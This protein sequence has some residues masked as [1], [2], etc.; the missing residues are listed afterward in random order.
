MEYVKPNPVQLKG[1]TN[2]GGESRLQEL[3][4]SDPS[5]LGLDGDVQLI[6]K[7]FQLPEGQRIDFLLGDESNRLQYEVEVQLGDLDESHIIRI[8]EYWDIMRKL[9]P[10]QRHIAVIVAE[11]ITSRFF[12]VI[13]LFNQFIP[14]VAIQVSGIEMDGKFTLVFTK[15]LDISATRTESELEYQ[16]TDRVYWESKASIEILK[17]ADKI[18]E[19]AKEFYPKIVLKYNKGYIGT[20]IDGMKSN[21][22]M[23]WPRKSIL[24]L[25]I[26]LP[27]SPEND[28]LCEEVG[29]D[30]DYD[31]EWSKYRFEFRIEEFE[32]YSSF[33]RDFLRRSFKAGG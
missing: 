29:L 31:P 11:K 23:F 26:Y 1:N 5:I 7:E 17:L 30:I 12:N 19:V 8:I 21:F 33:I 18:L 3:I 32:K 13:G 15:V 28:G 10:K 20:T 22:L 27:S 4:A 14:F 16:P 24:K 6:G 25:S 9:Y 2:F